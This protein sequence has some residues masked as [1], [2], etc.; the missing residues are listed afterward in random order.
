[1]AV[2]RINIGNDDPGA[3][4]GKEYCCHLTDTGPCARNQTDFIR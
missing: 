4:A 2:F 1:M 3:F